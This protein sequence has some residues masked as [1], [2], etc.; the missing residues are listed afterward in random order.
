MFVL[1]ENQSSCQ[2]VVS[3]EIIG[4]LVSVPESKASGI[5]FGRV[6]MPLVIV[7]SLGLLNPRLPSA[8]E[9]LH[10]V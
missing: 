8:V 5:V 1:R 3:N 7:Y 2:F 4:S 6:P 10:S 9:F